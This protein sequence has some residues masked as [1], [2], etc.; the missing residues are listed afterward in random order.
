M[1]NFEFNKAPQI[2]EG[3]LSFEEAQKLANMAREY[4]DVDPGI[5]KI[6]KEV[7]VPGGY[8]QHDHIKPTK[9]DYEK[10]I[11]AIE[12]LKKLVK[13]EPD[14]KKVIFEARRIFSKAGEITTLALLSPAYILTM[15][16]KGLDNR[17]ENITKTKES[18]M[19]SNKTLKDLEKKGNKWGKEE[20]KE[21][22]QKDRYRSAA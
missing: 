22:Q 2:K 16:A 17:R 20:V 4:L 8:I 6:I 3:Q 18:L 15:D 12:N 19:D 21:K 10:A 9:E 11:K 7:R 1:K 5:G 13:E 14:R